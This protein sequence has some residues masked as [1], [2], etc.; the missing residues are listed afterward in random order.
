MVRD[1]A[2]NDF[3]VGRLQQPVDGL[4][5]IEIDT[6]FLVDLRLY[7]GINFFKNPPRL[8]KVYKFG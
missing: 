6:G 8:D 3:Q 4:D 5:R 7:P 2:V 1:L